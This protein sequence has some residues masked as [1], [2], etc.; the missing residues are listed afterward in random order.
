MEQEQIVIRIN[1]GIET[2]Q[3]MLLLYNQMKGLIFTIAK[4]YSGLAELDDLFQEGVLALYEAVEHYNSAEKV[5]FSSYAGIVIKRHILRYIRDNHNLGM[6]NHMQ[7]VL[8]QYRQLCNYYQVMYGREPEEWEI[9]QYLCLDR[10]KAK[11]I[12]KAAA[13]DKIAR[14]DS[15]MKDGEEEYTLSEM[16]PSETNVEGELLEG[17]HQEQLRKVLWETVEHLPEEQ[18]KIIINRYLK[19][20]SIKDTG[21][22]LGIPSGKVS[23][24]EQKALRELRAEY[25]EELIHFLPEYL[26]AKAYHGSGVA[27]FRHDWTSSTERVALLLEES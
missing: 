5:K 4:H 10:I 7:S 21:K 22:Y 17:L 27:A 3:N 13:M 16:I 25:R 20:M 2:A 11:E 12:K 23:R 18:S 6:S 1:A 9:C 24:T 8:Y 14:L 26:E 15:P 19:D